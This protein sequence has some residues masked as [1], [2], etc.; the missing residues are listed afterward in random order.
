MKLIIHLQVK[1]IQ[2]IQFTTDWVDATKKEFTDC[3]FFEADSHSEAYTIQQ[4][5]Q[6]LKEA[7]KI[8][9]ILDCSEDESVS[10]LA[11]LIEKIMRSKQSNA[12][13]IMN[14]ENEMLRKMLT[15]FRKEIIKFKS[16]AAC[17]SQVK[18]Y[19]NSSPEI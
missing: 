12:L 3:L 15:L 7:S 8:V 6:F 11:P 2:K 18:K 5:I 16:T 1:P 10:R 14:G 19:L 13:V 17:I 9:L 4:G